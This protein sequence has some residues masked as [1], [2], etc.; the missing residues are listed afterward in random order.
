MEEEECQRGVGA[1]YLLTGAFFELGKYQAHHALSQ[2]LLPP[3]GTEES[4]LNQLLLPKG[5]A[6]SLLQKQA[7]IVTGSRQD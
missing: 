4:K 2:G 6:V 3:L 1:T 5:Q 7:T